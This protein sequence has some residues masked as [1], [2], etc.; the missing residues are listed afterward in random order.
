MEHVNYRKK[1]I[2]GQTLNTE[3]QQQP[4]TSVRLVAFLSTPSVHTFSPALAHRAGW[5]LFF[6][7]QQS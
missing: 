4:D 2:S 7:S 6:S 3:Q 1:L 5:L